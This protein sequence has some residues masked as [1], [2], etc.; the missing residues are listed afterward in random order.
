MSPPADSCESSV[1]AHGFGID[2]S[3]AVA[4]ATIIQLDTHGRS[5]EACCARDTSVQS[6]GSELDVALAW[7]GERHGCAGDLGQT[8]IGNRQDRVLCVRAECRKDEHLMQLA[9]AGHAIPEQSEL[10]NLV[11]RVVG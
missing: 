3:T 6:I 1:H 8:D 2:H 9:A 7:H 11:P 5:P 10:A 4:A